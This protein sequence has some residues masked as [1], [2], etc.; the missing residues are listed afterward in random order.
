MYL[1]DRSI[2]IINIFL[3]SENYVLVE[4]L[5][6]RLK[7][8]KRTIYNEI[9]SLNRAFI[10]NNLGPIHQVRGLGY[11]LNDE[12]KEIIG[13]LLEDSISY[14][15]IDP[16]NR[17][18][19]IYCIFLGLDSKIDIDLLVNITGV[20]RNTLFSDL[21]LIRSRMERYN[22][23]LEYNS[24]SGYIVVGD[25]IQKRSLFMYHYIPLSNAIKDKD[26]VESLFVVNSINLD[27]TLEKL[28]TIE[29]RL[30][31]EYIE[32]ALYNLAV[33]MSIEKLNEP[34]ESTEIN[35]VEEVINSTEYELI[36]ELFS[37]LSYF[38]KLYY[39]IH[40]LGSMK[41]IRGYNPKV[42]QF[43]DIAIEMVEKFQKLAAIEFTQVTLLVSNLSNHLSISMYRYK[44]GLHQS[45]PLLNQIKSQYE[46]VFEI[47]NQVCDVIRNRLHVIVS[48]S[49]VAYIALHF[50][51]FI[52]R[53]NFH[54]TNEDIIIVCPQGLSTSAMLKEEI[55]SMNPM[56]RINQTISLKQFINIEKDLKAKYIISTVEL[57]T[58]KKYI[59]VD[60]VLS[61]ADRQMLMRYFSH[62]NQN[63]YP[64][65]A[66]KIMEVVRPYI[67]DRDYDFL[68]NDLE[69]YLTSLITKKATNSLSIRDVL[70][71]SMVGI[72]R[73]T[74][75]WQEGIRLS[76]ERLMRYGFVEKTY[77]KAAIEAT[78]KFGA[79]M[80]LENG[81]MLV[82]ASINDGVNALGLS[83]TK[84]NKPF[85]IGNKKVDKVF[86]LSPIDQKQH[87]KIMGDLLN[88]FT[89]ETLHILIDEANS[90]AEILELILQQ[91]RV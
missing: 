24:K 5:A 2:R 13:S 33:L 31:T 49:E 70:S 1:E 36:N 82:H 51:S 86:S 63:K 22:L 79:Y 15:I 74:V 8:S 21:K 81:Y 68:L 25:L 30:Q 66:D 76:C 16:E 11:K 83:F 90:E 6:E 32:G 53:H 69:N 12:Q 71:M 34:N 89:N 85:K 67:S 91:V 29:D 52:R 73:E 50:N 84:F 77:H 26:M 56:I 88:V 40:L 44:F 18:H 65:S 14:R 47:S 23:K 3:K 48:E 75:T 37:N 61:H 9:D 41:Q 46:D 64:I 4:T 19:L 35:S 57:P 72:V 42:F 54:E 20:S 78:E 87:L 80:V 38:N 28:K 17:V 62:D 10:E 55:E 43:I 59:K 45:N 60:P 27:E 58:P 7:V 39:S